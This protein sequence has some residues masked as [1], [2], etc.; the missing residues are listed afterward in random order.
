MDRLT[1]S[2]GEDVLRAH[3]DSMPEAVTILSACTGS[4]AFELAAH[5]VFRQFE[6]VSDKSFEVTSLTYGNTCFFSVVICGNC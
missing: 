2:V 4:G 1:A 3:V 6:R 5:A